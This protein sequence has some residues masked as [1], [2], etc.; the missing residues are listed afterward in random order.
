MI[1]RIVV[2]VLLMAL[3]VTVLASP[4]RHLRVKR[5]LFGGRPWWGYMGSNNYGYSDSSSFSW[6]VNQWGSSNQ[7]GNNFGGGFPMFG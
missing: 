5:Q 4:Y 6:S 7:W 1:S 3:V 2:V